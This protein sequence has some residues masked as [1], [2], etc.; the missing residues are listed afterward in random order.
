M[1]AA[2]DSS[3]ALWRR[4]FAAADLAYEPAHLVFFHTRVSTG[5]GPQGD[6]SGPFYCPAD[7][8]VYLNTDFFDSLGRTFGLESP[9]AA[10]YIVGHEVGHHVQQQLG[11]LAQVNRLA[12]EDPAGV[13]G[14]SVR[15][16]LQA[17]CYAG[18]WARS[19][20]GPGSGVEI[21]GSDVADALEAAEAIGDD[22]I[23]EQAGMEVNPESW[24][25]G[26][27]EQRQEWFNRGF[28]GGQI[29]LCDTFDT[30]L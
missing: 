15:V 23:Q 14:R 12:E 30:E 3:Q 1:R 6:S 8:T 22:R 16:E 27:S 29:A 10:G 28:E 20:F 26:S 4:Q 5:C 17:D 7:H 11:T 18:L 9:F 25:H 13:N 24:T 19:V 21:S 2:F